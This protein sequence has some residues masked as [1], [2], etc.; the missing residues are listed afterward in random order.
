M[1]LSIIIPCYNHGSF[2]MEALNSIDDTKFNLSYEVIIVN[3]GSTEELTNRILN[4]LD[5][6][7]YKIIQQ[8]NQGLAA[9]RNNGI[10]LAKGKYILPLDCD[11][12]LHGN[13][14]SKAINIL[15]NDS[16]IDV[17]YGNPHFF[18]EYDGIRTEGLKLVGAF[19]FS[20][21]IYSNYI[22]ACAI[23]KKEIWIKAGGYDGNMPAMGHEDWEFWINIFFL[24]GKFYYL[25]ELCFYYRILPNS[26]LTSNTVEKHNRNKEYIYHKY[27]SKI[28]EQ[29]LINIS[30]LEYKD[31]Y[32]KNNKIKTIAKLILG[33][34]I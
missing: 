33:Y 8:H 34:E 31:E 25:N 18:G 15:N 26:M 9:A 4:K 17:L 23:F 30:E 21:I 27:S 5:R 11:N 16:S 12:R 13:Y 3:D 29:L 14:L 28:I 2:L 6:H 24:G 1:I 32:V 22:D 10:L 19:K 7:K 20:K